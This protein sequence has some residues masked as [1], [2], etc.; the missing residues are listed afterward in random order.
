M[1]TNEEIDKI[2]Q[3]VKRGVFSGRI[4]TPVDENLQD[5]VV[6]ALNVGVYREARQGSE[7]SN[8]SK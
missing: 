4:E 5:V 3:T 8:D 6:W 1:L 2:A 7:A